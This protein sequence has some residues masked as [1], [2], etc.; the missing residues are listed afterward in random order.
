MTVG[1]VNLA[2]SPNVSLP[3]QGFGYL[4]PKHEKSS[5]LGVIFDSDSLP[6]QSLDGTLRLTVMMGGYRFES[7]FGNPDTVDNNTLL[8]TA[9]EAVQSHLGINAD[10]IDS[11]VSIHKNCIPQYVVGHANKMK[12]LHFLIQGHSTLANRLSLV[13]A[14]YTGVGINDCIYESKKTVDRLRQSSTITGLENFV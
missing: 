12:Q 9:Q 5:I 1:V 11:H 7:L 14:S 2:F 13:G 4:I 8:Q 3:V 10:P 6:Q